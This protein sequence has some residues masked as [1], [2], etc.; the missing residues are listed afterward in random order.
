[1]GR[2]YS[3][4]DK[5]IVDLKNYKRG[6]LMRRCRWGVLFLVCFSTSY[7][8][9]GFQQATGPTNPSV[10]SDLR[11]DTYA[12]YSAL[13]SNPRRDPVP[14]VIYSI[15]DTTVP[16]RPGARSM[17]TEVCYERSPA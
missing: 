1:M 7:S 13:L 2:E 12:V 10:N 16:L 8:V 3:E 14:D 6:S 11:E 5:N 17:P 15:Q 9:I 4:H